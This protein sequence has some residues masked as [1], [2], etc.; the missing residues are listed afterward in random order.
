MEIRP[1]LAGL[2]RP[3]LRFV[4]F[5]QEQRSPVCQNTVEAEE[6]LEGAGQ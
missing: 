4:Y 3:S 6:A 2:D 5:D 1:I